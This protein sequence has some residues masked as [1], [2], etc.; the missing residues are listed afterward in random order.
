MGV[1]FFGQFLLENNVIKPDELT[2]AIECWK[3]RQ[4]DF[5]DCAISKGYMTK[6]DLVRLKEMQKGVDMRFGEIAVR[7]NILTPAQVDDILDTQKTDNIYLGEALVKSG[8]MTN[9]D[10]QRELAL[11]REDQSKYSTNELL[12]PE[13]V[14]NPEIV[15]EIVS[16]TQKLFNRV[17][18]L[19]IKIDNG[20]VTN[21]EPER[22]FLIVSISLTG[23]HQYEYCLSLP[24]NLSKLVT[25]EITGETV[26]DNASELVVDGIREFCNI[27]C[28]SIIAKLSHKGKIMDISTPHV[29]EFSNGSYHLVKGR[30][31]ICYS[32][33]STEDKGTLMLIEKN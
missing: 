14:V 24:E 23:I 16:L 10:L 32:L 20:Y 22:N 19:S 4:I 33:V 29:A 5:G 9:E 28:G 6:E 8:F 7:L 15:R 13:N 2:K 30:K 21:E 11:F 3:Q 25:S 26:K 18:R 31:T 1:K 17:A 12:V 27:V